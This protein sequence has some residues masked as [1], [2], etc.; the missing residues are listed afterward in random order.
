[1]NKFDGSLKLLLSS[2]SCWAA[3]KLPP[4]IS[5]EKNKTTNQDKK[6]TK[7]DYMVPMR[8]MATMGFLVTAIWVITLSVCE[9]YFLS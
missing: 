8:F 7:A 2:V 4:K 3:V 9:T 1:M 6:M 5:V